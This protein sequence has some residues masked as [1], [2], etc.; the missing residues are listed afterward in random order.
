MSAKEQFEAAVQEHVSAGKSRA[1]ATAAVVREQ[2]ELQQA[3]IDEA[4]ENRRR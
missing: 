2:P 3:M 1:K 4:N